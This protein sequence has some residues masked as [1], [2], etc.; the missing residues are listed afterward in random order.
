MGKMNFGSANSYSN[1][2]LLWPNITS[3]IF[4]NCGLDTLS[5]IPLCESLK[6]CSHISVIDFSSIFINYYYL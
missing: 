3:L 5:V 6:Y 2:L 1:C 4:P